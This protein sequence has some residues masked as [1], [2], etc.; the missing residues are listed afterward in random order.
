METI[1]PADPQLRYGVIAQEVLRRLWVRLEAET[2]QPAEQIETVRILLFISELS[3]GCRRE[4]I[5]RFLRTKADAV[6]K[7]YGIRIRVSASFRSSRASNARI[8]S[9][10]GVGSVTPR[11]TQPRIKAGDHRIIMRNTRCER[12][13][14][15]AT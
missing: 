5:K 2:P 6:A 7:K 9:G 8:R 12:L 3:I 13:R 1:L 10:P 14:G 4:G 15:Y 11:M